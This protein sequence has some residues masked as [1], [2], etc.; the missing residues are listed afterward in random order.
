MKLAA[1]DTNPVREADAMRIG[2]GRGDWIRLPLP[3]NRT[4][5]SPTSGSPV[6]GSPSRGLTQQRLG[7][8]KREQPLRGKESI[9]P[10]PMIISP[11]TT[12]PFT[13]F[14]QNATQAHPDPLIQRPKRLVVA[15]F[16]VS[17][18][19]LCNSVDTRDDYLQA[20]PIVALGQNPDFVL[21]LL[22]ALLPRP[23]IATLEVIPKKVKAARFYGIHNPR[24]LRVQRQ[25]SFRR[26]LLH[27]GQGPLSFCLTA[28]QDDKVVG[29]PHHLNPLLG[30]QVVQR[31]EI[32]VREQW[33]DDRPLRSTRFGLPPL[34][35]FQH[36]LMQVCFNQCQH[37]SIRDLLFHPGEQWLERD[38]VE[39]AFQVRINY[40]VVALLQQ[41]VDSPQC[42]L[43]T[44]PRTKPVA[45]CREDP[46]EDWFQHCAQ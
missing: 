42:S 26:P 32:N 44:P 40:P 10:A 41:V 39:V 34:H 27:Q 46:F 45:V 2:V 1:I 4:G 17:N 23:F 8:S 9:G 13:A 7:G 14:A 12:T 18:P 24:L 36:S 37:C 28:T 19:A 43:A 5:G 6:G 35:G 21:H 22:Q 25:T 20:L 38:S 3:P 33:T 16:E 31:I 29:V 30:Q 15:M 11:S